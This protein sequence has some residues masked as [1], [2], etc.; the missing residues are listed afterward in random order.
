MRLIA[1]HGKAGAGKDTF[2]DRLV[3][4]HGFVKRGFADALYEEVATAF[5]VGAGWLRDRDR[6]EKGQDLLRIAR[7]YDVGF[8]EWARAAGHNGLDVRSPRWI[9]QQWGTGYRRSQKDNYWLEKM[10]GLMAE[11]VGF[12][13][14]PAGLVIPDCRFLNEA[15]WVRRH[16]GTIIK[17]V[18]TRAPA[19]HEH[20]SETPLPDDVIDRII[21]N[22]GTISRLHAVADFST[23][24][25][26][27]ARA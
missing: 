9:L 22:D 27:A 7:C 11:E 10:D 3:E 5:G 4:A 19:V 24:E 18:R 26:R 14:H 23:R 25:Y 20:V 21:F 6:K 8:V 15:W 12:H 1:L 17:I 13:A 16:I 2:A